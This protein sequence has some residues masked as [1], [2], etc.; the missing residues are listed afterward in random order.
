MANKITSFIAKQTGTNI[1]NID[2][3]NSI[4]ETAS[5][6]YKADIPVLAGTINHANIPYQKFEVHQNEFFKALVDRIGTTVIKALSYENPLAIFKSEIFEF[7]DVLQEIYV[8]PATAEN[9]DGKD[10]ISPFKFSDTDIEVFY[11]KLN[12][13]K[14]YTR[15]FERAWVQKAFISDIAF[16]EFIDKMFTSLLS[17]DSLDEYQAVKSVLESSLAEIDYTDLTGTAKKITV[18]GTKID[19]TQSDFIVDFNQSLINMSKKFTIPSRSVNYNP[20]GVPNATPV[21]EQYLIISAEYSTHLDMLLANAF[22]MDKASVLARQIVIDDFAQF[23]GA[24]ANN[25]KKP[26]A[27]LVSAKSIILK[28]KLVHMESIRNPRALNYN[29]FYHHHYLTSLSMFE[30]IHMWY[31]E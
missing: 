12:N 22:N 14:L 7:G 31:T 23:T 18:S 4:R 28:D 9:Y 17:S 5:D 3:L 26:V 6:A 27:F 1:S 15:T 20:V 16:D 8:H 13:E 29:Y 21:D 2:L 25:G 11:H 30:N 10:S 24:G 19:E